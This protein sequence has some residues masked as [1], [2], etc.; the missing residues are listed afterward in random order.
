M[1]P[2]VVVTTDWR[3]DAADPPAAFRGQHQRGSRAQAMM[4]AAERKTQPGIP[5]A[6]AALWVAD[7][8]DRS[9]KVAAEMAQDTHRQA[10]Y[11]AGRGRRVHGDK[12]ARRDDLG[13]FRRR[14]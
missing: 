6:L 9:G 13:R 5:A 10:E 3:P 2:G 8:L 4:R 12:R 7:W 14:R 11:R 1:P